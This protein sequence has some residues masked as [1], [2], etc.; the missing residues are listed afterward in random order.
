M[1]WKAKVGC[2]KQWYNN[3]LKKQTN[4]QT[5]KQKL[6]VKQKRSWPPQK[7]FTSK[8]NKQ[9]WPAV[10]AITFQTPI[11]TTLTVKQCQRGAS[12]ETGTDIP[13]RYQVL[14]RRKAAVGREGHVENSVSSPLRVLT[15]S[16]RQDTVPPPSCIISPHTGLAAGSEAQ[17]LHHS[18]EIYLL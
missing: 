6:I 12:R 9:I 15:Q 5:N 10:S 16:S 8:L 3:Q 2:S 11:Y 1:G 7:T 17:N 13:Q 14:G 18:V 4:E